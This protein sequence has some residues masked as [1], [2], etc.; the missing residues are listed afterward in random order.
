MRALAELELATN[1]A[2]LGLLIVFSFSEYELL[3]NTVVD[4]LN[5][6]IVPGRNSKQRVRII[7][8]DERSWMVS[9]F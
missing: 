5:L 2:L 9:S 8:N 7:G 4:Y 3:L 6:L 1:C